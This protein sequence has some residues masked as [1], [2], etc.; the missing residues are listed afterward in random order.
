MKAK[1]CR[2][3]VPDGS[4]MDTVHQLLAEADCPV[5]YPSSRAY[6]GIIA[7]HRLF[8]PPFH[9][10][11][12]MRPWD[13]PLVVAAQR[14]ELAFTG[15]D[16][17]IEAGCQ[18]Q[19]VVLDKYP[20]SRGGVGFTK[21]V[22]AVTSDSLIKS[23][24]DLGP[25]HQVATEYPN[26]ARQWLAAKGVNPRI[27]CCH[28][29]LE[30]FADF[31]DAIFE[32]TETGTSLKVG[33]WRIIEDLPKSQTCLITYSQALEDEVQNAII[34]EFRI[35]L[36]AVMAARGRV[37]IKCNVRPENCTSIAALLPSAG[38]PTMSPLFGNDGFALEAV[39]MQSDVE[40]LLPALKK[41]GAT[42]IV[43]HNIDKF[44]P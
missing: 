21:L 4:L 28:G 42:A 27:V 25:Q 29:S 12:R 26:Y 8:P 23:V 35:L 36:N 38:R 32:N 11:H 20:L 17:I 10:V 30:A 18:D 24:T 6:R 2:L 37:M 44:L 14:A 34:Q 39:V 43:V 19:V 22:L 9:L 31:A 5:S 41:A 7:N 13:S 1:G 3:I 16:L 33:G 40:S 15:Q